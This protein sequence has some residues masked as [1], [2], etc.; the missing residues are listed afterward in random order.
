MDNEKELSLHELNWR[1]IY[2]KQKIV[3]MILLGNE[4]IANAAQ[5]AISQPNALEI[6]NSEEVKEFKQ[7]TE[8]VLKDIA[9]FTQRISE[10]LAPFTKL[11]GDNSPVTLDTSPQFY[12]CAVTLEGIEREVL[13]V[14][15]RRVDYLQA[16]TSRLLDGV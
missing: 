10:G 2:E 14:M 1:E 7:Q 6:L 13:T 5:K 9:E 4:A 8:I 15:S 11:M 12:A 16:A 3:L